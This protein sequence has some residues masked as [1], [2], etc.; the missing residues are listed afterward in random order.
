MREFSNAFFAN[1]ED[2]FLRS[3]LKILRYITT[4]TSRRRR[5]RH[6]HHHHHHHHLQTSLSILRKT[7]GVFEPQYAWAVAMV[8]KPHE[9]G[10]SDFIFT[11]SGL[12]QDLENRFSF[13]YSSFQATT[14]FLITYFYF[15]PLF[16]LFSLYFAFI[17]VL[18]LYTLV[19]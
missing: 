10:N 18:L 16:F 8:T 1:R 19:V 5:R 12:H 15:P 14:C 3:S 2:N 17:N 4:T 11:V 13:F 6:H 7:R 9:D